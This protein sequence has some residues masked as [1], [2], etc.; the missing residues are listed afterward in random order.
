M[1]ESSSNSAYHTMT[2][3]AEEVLRDRIVSGFYPSNSRLIPTILEKEL[4][5]GRV[6]IREALKELAGKGLVQFIPNRGAVVAP[7]ISPQELE[8]IFELRYELEGKAAFQAAQRITPEELEELHRLNEKTRTAANAQEYF[9]FNRTFHLAL[10][11]A[12]GWLFLQRTIAL[13]YD[14]MLIVRSKFPP[15]LTRAAQFAD[16]HQAILDALQKQDGELAKKCTQQHISWLYD[17][18]RKPS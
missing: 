9:R 15:D 6:P 18:I 17:I 13:L 5:L 10:Y 14:Q 8:Q 4:S 12:S 1:N 3:L 7:A 2:E 11:Q 16:E